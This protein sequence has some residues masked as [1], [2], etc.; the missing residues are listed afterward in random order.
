MCGCKLVGTI[1]RG[2]CTNMPDLR[3]LALAGNR[4]SGAIPD[5]INKLENLR[6][7]WLQDNKMCGEIPSVANLDELRQMDISNNDESHDIL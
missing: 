4:L 6:S 7:L 5:D 3:T 1:P 2:I